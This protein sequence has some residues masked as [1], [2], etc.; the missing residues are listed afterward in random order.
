MWVVAV[1]GAEQSED[2]ST[3]G[4]EFAVNLDDWELTELKVATL[5]SSWEFCEF[6]ANVLEGNLSMSKK[7][8]DSLSAT[9]T[10]EIVNL[11]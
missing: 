10:G 3:L 9:V 11:D 5:L 6:V 4:V 2:G 7:H 8:S 1:L